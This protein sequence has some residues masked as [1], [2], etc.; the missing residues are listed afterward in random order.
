VVLLAGAN[1]AFQL[2][3]SPTRDEVNKAHEKKKWLDIGVPSF[4]NLGHIAKSR[5]ILAVS[6]LLVGVA[7]QVL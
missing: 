6:V 2:L 5:S 4:R 7:T 1:Y 3:S